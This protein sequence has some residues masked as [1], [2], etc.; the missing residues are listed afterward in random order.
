MSF[1]FEDVRDA[2]AGLDE[3]KHNR[4]QIPVRSGFSPP[5]LHNSL[6]HVLGVDADLDITVRRDPGDGVDAST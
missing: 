5:A 1:D 2:S 6:R 4:P 3:L